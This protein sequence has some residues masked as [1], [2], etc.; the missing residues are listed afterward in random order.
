[1]NNFLL[2]LISLILFELFIK[3]IRNYY[4]KMIHKFILKIYV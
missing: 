2:K 1:M 4:D 3:L